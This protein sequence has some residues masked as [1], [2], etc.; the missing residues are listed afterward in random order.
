MTNR[1]WVSIIVVCAGIAFVAVAVSMGVN[2]WLAVAIAVVALV[3]NGLLAQLEDD[4]PGGFNNPDGANTPK[5]VKVVAWAV[6][7]IG[8]VAVVL[9]VA[10]FAVRAFG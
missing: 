5:Y 1:L 4:V 2:V 6:R 7:G 3:A 9:I 8:A 10:V